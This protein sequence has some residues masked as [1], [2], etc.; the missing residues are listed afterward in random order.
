VAERTT[1]RAAPGAVVHRWPDIPAGSRLSGHVAVLAEM[2]LRTPEH[3]VLLSGDPR[4]AEPATVAG[5][6]RARL[7]SPFRPAAR[8]A[9]ALRPDP[10]VPIRA[11]GRG[12]ILLNELC[13][14]VEML[15]GGIGTATKGSTAG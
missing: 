13:D 9:L 7:G 8:L 15:T 14:V 2:W 1:A 4:V 6:G 10:A 5:H 12:L 11:A 3:Y